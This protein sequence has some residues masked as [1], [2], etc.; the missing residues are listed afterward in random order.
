VATTFVT[1]AA[2]TL[3]I[4]AVAQRHVRAL[5]RLR[6]RRRRNSI[7]FAVAPLAIVAS[8]PPGIVAAAP[9]IIAATVTLAISAAGTLAIA[10]PLVIDAAAPFAAATLVIVAA[11]AVILAAATTFVLR[12]FG[13]SWRLGSTISLRW[14]RR[15]HLQ[16]ADT[17]ATAHGRLDFGLDPVALA[18]V[19]SE[20]GDWDVDRSA[21]PHNATCARFNSKF[22]CAGAESVDAFGQDWRVGTSFVL[23]DF[24]HTAV[25]RVLDKVERDNARVVLIVPR[26]TKAPWWR[27]LHAPR[28]RARVARTLDLAG[29]D[30]VPH[31]ENARH[32]FFDRTFR[33]DLLAVLLVPF[34]AA[35]LGGR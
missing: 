18:L 8:A 1:V 33:N 16:L 31:H 21:A 24:R 27:R 9:L 15:E 26:W 32:C 12:I 14:V 25:D 3:I 30:L 6:Y 23:G 34:H 4:V 28:F 2:A 22:H 35:P 20:L 11:A 19:R 10:A 29:S 7:I 5:Q 13:T 17:V